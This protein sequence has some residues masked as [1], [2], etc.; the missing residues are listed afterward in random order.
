[1]HVISESG[2]HLDALPQGQMVLLRGPIGTRPRLVPITLLFEVV[3][4]AGER[5]QGE[6][7]SVA[8]HERS[9]RRGDWFTAD[10]DV[11][12]AA[13]DRKLHERRTVRR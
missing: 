10:E 11:Q 5:R 7:R 2:Q 1:M 9:R 13:L 12:Y 6:R 8:R 3:R 4:C